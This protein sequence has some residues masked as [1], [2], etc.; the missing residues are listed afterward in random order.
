MADKKA[1][2][3]FLKKAVKG[4]TKGK[5]KAGAK[6]MPGMAA[7]MAKKSPMGGYAKMKGAM[8]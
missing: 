3:S 4:A 5:A 8:A 1:K 6:M 7:M 2:M